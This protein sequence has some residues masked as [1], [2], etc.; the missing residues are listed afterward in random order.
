MTEPLLKVENLHAGV[1]G[2]TILRGVDL[3][4]NPG[5]VHAIM[6]PNGSGKSTLSHI[7]AGR[8]GY[9][10]TG[11]GADFQ[12]RDLLALEPE[13][14]A[15]AGLFLALQ[16]PVEIPGVNNV[17]LLKAGLNAVRK[18][19]GEPE[20]DAYEF[21]KIARA[22]LKQLG[23]DDS[24][25]NRGVNEGFS[26]GE[27]KRNEILQM[28]V[29]EPTLALL[30]ETDSG[31]DIDALKVVADGVNSL[32]APERS[33]VLVTHYQRL[34]DYIEPDVVHVLMNGRIVRSGDASLAR[35]LEERGYDWLRAETA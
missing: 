6:G 16:Y 8:P 9:E 19:R 4:V 30:D 13:E 31:L 5:E 33:F 14:R 28:L 3:I 18:S 11:G 25:L 12:G 26:G 23:L 29:F 21:L 10:V 7:L 1:E 27:K 32:R 22:K 15:C 24:F 2:K 20:L 35:T 34:L 17:Y